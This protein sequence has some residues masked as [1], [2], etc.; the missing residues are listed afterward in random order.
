MDDKITLIIPTHERHKYLER[1]LDYYSSATFRIIVGDSTKTTF[2]KLHKFKNIEY[3]HLPDIP[4]IEKL[5]KMLNLVE[6]PYAVFCADDDFIIPTGLNE[7]IKFLEENKDY[8]VAHG[9]YCSFEKTNDKYSWRKA[10]YKHY[11]LVQENPLERFIHHFSHYKLPTFYAVHRTELLRYVWKCDLKDINDARFGELLPTL[12]ALI[13]GKMKTLDI[14]YAARERIETSTGRTEN[15]LLDYIY[16][17]EFKDKYNN[18]RAFLSNELVQHCNIPFN[19]AEKI[20]DKGMKG[21]LVNHYGHSIGLLKLKHYTKNFLEKLGLLTAARTIR[22]GNNRNIPPVVPIE[23]NNSE[24][25]QY[26]E[27]LKID[28]IVKK[29]N[30]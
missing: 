17:G 3:Y 12:I 24:H 8:V 25:P 27:W 9:Q 16:T 13:H 23:Y 30:I 1:V 28:K 4:I 19:E 15:T 21:Y 14:F 5:N 29:Y 2:S 22:G 11:S 7:S 18:V 6:S 26:Q 20:V 10:E